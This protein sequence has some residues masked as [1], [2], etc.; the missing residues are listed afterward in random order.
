MRVAEGEPAR[1][2]RVVDVDGKEIALEDYRG[3]WLLL[4]FSRYAACPL[5]VLRV[6][7]IVE[8]YPDL[9]AKGLDVLMFFQSPRES[10]LRYLDEFELPFPVVADPGM[11]VYNLYGVELSWLGYVKAAGRLSELREARRRGYGGEP[12]GVK[13]LVPADFLMGPDLVVRRAHY[14]GDIGDHLSLCLIPSY[15]E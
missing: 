10:V 14:G 4:S 8:A 13:A 1:D 2:F 7:H 15:L 9:H 12:E 5:C 6:S 3:R 11:E